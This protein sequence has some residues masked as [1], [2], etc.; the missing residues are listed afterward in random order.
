MFGTSPTL[1]ASA[2]VITTSCLA[3]QLCAAEP[4]VTETREGGKSAI[5]ITSA[6]GGERV[7][8][9][10][11]S[12]Q[13][14]PAAEKTDVLKKWESY[15]LGAF[16]CFNTNQFTGEESCKG[17][18]AKVYNPPQVDVAGWVTV[19][20]EAGM[21]Y[22]V[23]TTRHTSGFLLWDSATTDFDVARS[24]N[25]T[26]VCKEFVEECRRQGL[27]PAFY[28][29]LWGGKDWHPH[30]NARAIILAQLYELATRY[31]E[32]P[33]FW[34]DMMNWAPADLST[35]EIY[36]MLKTLQPNCVVEF[37]QHVQDGSKIRYF[38]TDVVDGELTP[39]PAAGH[40]PFRTID[41]KTY[42]LPFDYNLVSQSR[43]GGIKY[44]PLGPSCWFTYGEG[45]KFTPSHPFA[46]EALAKQ[47]RL[48]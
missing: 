9:I 41:G 12:R 29:C 18:D 7:Y 11:L 48:G 20:K 32:I 34:I 1:V 37:N 23:L 42:Y 30:T 38:P 28:Y 25:T 36:N 14:T 44:D 35:Q 13:H 4:V 15:R 16:V 26:E 21:K 3:T 19:F 5:H 39:P 33:Y 47:I 6:D 40:N 10:D 17:R 43:P 27:T 22:A 31:G 2:M 45:K 46:A 24:G 8:R